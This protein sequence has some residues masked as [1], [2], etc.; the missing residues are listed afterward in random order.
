MSAVDYST[1]K[2]RFTG[3]RLGLKLVTGYSL[4]TSQIPNKTG[5]FNIA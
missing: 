1:L 4:F 3:Y 5:T 2:S